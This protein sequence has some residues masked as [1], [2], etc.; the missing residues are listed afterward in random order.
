MVGQFTSS[1]HRSDGVARLSPGRNGCDAPGCGQ[2]SRS[3]GFWSDELQVEL[4]GDLLAE[5]E[6][7]DAERHVEVDAEVV[8]GDL[9]RGA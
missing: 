9:C 8:T 3:V 2:E 5:R 6:A 4:D 1:G 7:V